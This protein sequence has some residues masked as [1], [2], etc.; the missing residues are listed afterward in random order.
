MSWWWGQVSLMVT[1]ISERKYSRSKMH[2]SDNVTSFPEA[3]HT[4]CLFIF[5]QIATTEKFSA[6]IWRTN[7]FRQFICESRAKHLP[8]K[9]TSERGNLTIAA[10]TMWNRNLVWNWCI[11]VEL[12]TWPSEIPPE[13]TWSSIR[14]IKWWN[15]TSDFMFALYK[16]WNI[17]GITVMK[18]SLPLNNPAVCVAVELSCGLV[19]KSGSVFHSGQWVMTWLEFMFLK[20]DS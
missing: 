7:T 3:Q 15:T 18:K 8:V 5:W 19:L 6:N 4:T 1:S 14:C 13:P 17:S 2:A 12:W 16:P 10:G 20:V 11:S 9:R